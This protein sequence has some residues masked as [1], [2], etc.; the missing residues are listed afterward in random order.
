MQVE[1]RFGWSSQ[2]SGNASIDAKVFEGS[3]SEHD[4][5]VNC[6]SEKRRAATL[7][8]IRRRAGVLASSFRVFFRLRRACERASPE[9]EVGKTASAD[10]SKRKAGS[11]E[12]TFG[13]R[14][15]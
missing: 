12:R 10:H 3:H 11:V 14:R 15:C 6:I 5:A 13:D 7:R 8:A 1:K 2:R 4:A 9:R